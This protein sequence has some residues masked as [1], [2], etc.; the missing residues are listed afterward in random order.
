MSSLNNKFKGAIAGSILGYWIGLHY[1]STPHLARCLTIG[2]GLD[3]SWLSSSDA[4]PPSASALAKRYTS[5]L[6][7][8]FNVGL[9]G[10]DQETIGPDDDHTSQANDSMVSLESMLRVLNNLM[11][12]PSKSIND[13][14]ND[15]YWLGVNTINSSIEAIFVLFP[16]LLLHHDH[17]VR[18]Q[19]LVK[20]WLLPVQ[21]PKAWLSDFEIVGRTVSQMMQA[22]STKQQKNVLLSHRIHSETKLDPNVYESCKAVLHS[23]G[24]YELAILSLICFSKTSDIQWHLFPLM[25]G[26][27]GGIVGSQCG[28]TRLPLVWRNVMNNHQQSLS[29]NVPSQPLDWSARF[30]AIWS[31]CEVG[32]GPSRTIPYPTTTSRMDVLSHSGNDR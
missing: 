22:D 10:A 4:S 13:G 21:P 28:F 18:Q 16:I 27:T 6:N 29:Q 3:W 11:D 31:G 32:C 9:E 12:Q 30:T 2:T 14:G 23:F 20:Q 7:Q 5:I 1:S 26:L 24:S 25:A 8:L 19:H 17:G 15:P